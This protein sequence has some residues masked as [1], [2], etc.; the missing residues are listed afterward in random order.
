MF[1]DYSRNPQVFAMK[2][3]DKCLLILPFFHIYGLGVINAALFTGT[4]II[5]LDAFEPNLFLKT[6]QNHRIELLLL[7]PTLVNFFAKS[8]LVE[9]Y[10]LSSVKR[11]ICAGSCLPEEDVVLL[12]NRYKH[13]LFLKML[14]AI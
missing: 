2:T 3:G 7:V 8:P 5:P 11:V 13:F 10:D 9:R 4:T 6:V 14:L 1:Q 12:K